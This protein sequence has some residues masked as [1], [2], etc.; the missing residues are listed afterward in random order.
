MSRRNIFHALGA[1]A[2]G[3]VLTSALPAQQPVN[4]RP[5]GKSGIYLSAADF[6]AGRMANEID[7][8]TAEHKLE[9]HEF[10]DR[11]YIHVTHGGRRIRYEK[12]KIFGVQNCDGTAIR[13]LANAD[14]Q[15][16]EVGPML[17]YS[18]PAYASAGFTTKKVSKYF[19]STAPDAAI[20]PLT[21]GNLRAAFA[22]NARFLGLLDQVFA[23]DEALGEFD[24]MHE[25]FRVNHVLEQS[26]T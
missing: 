18:T 9:L 16:A 20:L 19:F 22:G 26:R 8:A 1:V 10:R 15:V 3:V 17:I 14:Y 23:S 4:P 25:M 5:A 21:K 24:R 2:A 13:F 6:T 12:A 11:P 7:C